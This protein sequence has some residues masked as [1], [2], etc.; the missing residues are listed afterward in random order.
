[1]V[2]RFIKKCLDSGLYQVFLIFLK[3]QPVKMWLG[4]LMAVLTVVAGITLLGLSGWFITATAIAGLVPFAFYS[5]DVFT[6]SA[7]IRL[8]AIGRTAARYGERMVTHSVTLK[9]IAELRE[10]LFRGWAQ[11]QAAQALLKRPAQLL[12]RLTVD[13]DAL[14][15]LYL[16]VV[17][18]IAAALI[19]AVLTSLAFGFWLKPWLGLLLLI[20]L[21]LV[22]IGVPLLMGWRALRIARLKA[23][24]SEALRARAVDMVAGQVELMMVGRMQAQHKAVMKANACISKADNEMNKMEVWVTVAHSC[25]TIVLVAAFLLGCAWMV[26]H[27]VILRE[28]VAEIVDGVQIW[29]KSPRIM[30]APIAAFSLLV[31]LAV[32]EPFTAIQRGA[33]EFGR[34][35]LAIKRLA[36]KLK[37]HQKHIDKTSEN[38][39]EN[40]NIVLQ[41]NNV[42]FAYPGTSRQV[43]DQ[44]CLS[45]EQGQKMAIVGTSGS[46]KSTLLAL[47]TGE[48]SPDFGEI[49]ATKLSML[50]QRTELFQDSV[51]GNLL[52]ANPQASDT[53]LWESLRRAGLAE[54]VELLSGMLDAKLG[55][56]GQGLSGGQARRLALARLFLRKS[57]LWLLDEPTEGL[58]FETAQ[59]VLSRIASNKQQAMLIATHMQR[60]AELADFILVFDKGQ[61]KGC[62]K[63]G[64][65]EYLYELCQL[66]PN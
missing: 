60:E 15:S 11:P 34:T 44:V 4:V 37:I 1:M 13:L 49:H 23:Y 25:A 33:V 65:P 51:K 38:L 45:I 9:V 58:D 57:P 29:I 43:I 66:K 50:T 32:F 19:V 2:N 16:R 63:Q 59:D 62:F 42:S 39:P 54:A 22:G 18:P 46:G 47:I 64:T 7:A 40:A 52:L 3:A 53:I 30:D 61:I 48:I 6:P 36:P 26:E 10:R 17:V 21:L 27:H 28:G 24:A 41:I 31:L 20:G 56:G 35:L 5:F 55:E 14:D 8:L 12:F